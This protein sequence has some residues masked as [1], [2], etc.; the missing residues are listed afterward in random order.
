MLLVSMT[1]INLPYSL[2]G[3]QH[4]FTVADEHVVAASG[5]IGSGKSIAGAIRGLLASLGQV[6]N[7]RIPTPN[8][9]IVTAPT[10]P[11]LKDASLRTFQ[12]IAGDLVV[13][14]NK[15]DMRATMINGSEILF[16]PASDPDRLRGPNAAWWWGDEGAYYGD[17]VFPIMVGR[18]RQHGKRGFLWVTTT[19]KGRNWFYKEFGDPAKARRL[20]KLRTIDNPFL[21]WDIIE[22]WS[23]TYVGD[24]AKQELEGEF[25]S[26]EGLI[27]SMFSR[28]LHMKSATDYPDQFVYTVAG[29]DWGFVHPGVILIFGVDYD[30]RMWL[31]HEE[32]HRKWQ[33]ETWV[34]VAKQLNQTYHPR[35]WYCD[36]SEPTYI[37][38]F[39]KAGCRA[40][41]ANNEVL[42]GIQRVQYRLTK[43]ADGLPRL[44][45]RKDSL[46]TAVEFE[47]YA[48]MSNK[49]G[50][51]EQPLKAND[52]S[53]DV[54][55]YICAG[56]DAARRGQITAKVKEI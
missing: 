41:G 23:E 36:P 35:T 13:D 5:G 31:L 39:V 56:L 17:K 18:L 25:I 47:Q 50:L 44:M 11:M 1:T 53:M 33:I 27:Y 16:R 52:H 42:P 2:Y 37:E 40:I 22:A 46:N 29:V 9:G 28:D 51:K 15:N 45:I 49:D 32:Y 34:E 26:Y 48:W 14:F 7:H 12:E 20:F 19:P 6:G 10:Y 54:I 38:K 55:K 43:Q 30:G 4:D 3:Q 8:L 24:F 21:D